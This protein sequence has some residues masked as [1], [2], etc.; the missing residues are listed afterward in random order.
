MLAGWFR[1]ALESSKSKKKKKK[2]AS[3]DGALEVEVMNYGKQP[4]TR[5]EGQQRRI[6]G[7]L[8]G[9]SRSRAVT[10]L[11]QTALRGAREQ[12]EES[13]WVQS[14]R[15]RRPAEG[16]S[17]TDRATERATGP[18]GCEAVEPHRDWRGAERLLMQMRLLR[19]DAA[20]CEH[21]RL[22][23]HRWGCLRTDEAVCAQIRLFAHRC[24][25]LYTDAALCAQVRLFAHPL[26]CAHTLR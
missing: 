25:C 14:V 9:R 13:A 3:F 2:E 10:S 6:R 4:F 12:V 20:G 22:F 1:F 7:G 11:P 26:L 15:R 8:D 5:A 21:M 16:A 24:G 18:T 17:S 23:T 19:T